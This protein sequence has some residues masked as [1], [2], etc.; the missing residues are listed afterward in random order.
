MS[1]TG[2]AFTFDLV[3]RAAAT[4]VSRRASLLTLGAA[5]LTALAV[6]S[7]AG[8]KK[9]KKNT[10]KKKAKQKCQKQEGQCVVSVLTLCE[11]NPDPD[12]CA[13]Q[14]EACCQFTASCDIVGFFNCLSTPA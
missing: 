8:A 1:M 12:A 4:G 5:G 9:N 14:V 2:N 3:A 10:T 6:P 7:L 13:A 11:G